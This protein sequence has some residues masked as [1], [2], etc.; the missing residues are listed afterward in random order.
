[1]NIKKEIGKRILEARKAKGLTLKALGELA[2]GLK[3][4]RL[5]NWE[6]GVR[7][8]GPEEI[9]LL[10]QTLDVSPAY[11]MCLSDEKQFKET[12]NPSRLIPLLDYQ[13][14]CEAKLHTDKINEKDANTEVVF[15]SVSSM[16]LP[17]LSDDAFAL[18][19]MDASMSPEIR[20]NDVLVVDPD[21]IPRPGSFVVA[22]LENNKEVLIRKYK[23]LS[24]SKANEEYELVALNH[25]WADIHVGPKEIQG[26]IIGSGVSLIRG[27]RE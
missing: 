12:I 20:V 9:K 25:D 24:A 22:L 4:T 11:L 16:L 18:K 23:Q 14:A 3:Q 1:M 6:Q 10:A 13:Q 5:T 21:I 26:R 8:P 17:E 27:L 2:G 15:I 19:M 7:T